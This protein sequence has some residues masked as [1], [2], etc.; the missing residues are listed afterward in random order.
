MT[1]LFLMTWSYSCYLTLR[2]WTVILYVFFLMM[3]S[4][5]QLL[6][7]TDG[8]SRNNDTTS[9]QVMGLLIQVGA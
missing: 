9:V 4:V 3:T 7:L 5:G 2:E 8:N 6:D 1:A